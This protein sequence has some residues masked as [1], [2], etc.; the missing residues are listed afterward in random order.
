VA[1]R[2]LGDSG[3]A[4]EVVQD[5]MTNIWRSPDRF[6]AERGSF[7]TWL[8]TLVRNRSIDVL[9]SRDKRERREVELPEKARATTEES[10]PWRSVSQSLERKTLQE[11]LSSIPRDQREAIE[12]TYFSGHSQRDIAERLQLPLGTVKGRQR[13]ALEKLHSFLTGRGFIHE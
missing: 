5:V 8:L 10:D 13:L 12:L 2:I 11:A 3:R 4:E 9:R 7:R 6:H 1:L